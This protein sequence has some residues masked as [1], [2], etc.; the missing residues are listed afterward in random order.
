M[1]DGVKQ[2]QSG[3]AKLAE[4][5]SIILQAGSGAVNQ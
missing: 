5:K 3:A 2:I 4:G 1:V